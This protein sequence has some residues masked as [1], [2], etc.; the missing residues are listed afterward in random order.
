MYCMLAPKACASLARRRGNA[1]GVGIKPGIIA[2]P[3]QLSVTGWLLWTCFL[4]PG[5]ERM[6][7]AASF[8]APGPDTSD[9]D[10]PFDT[11]GVVD[12]WSYHHQTPPRSAGSHPAMG[13]ANRTMGAPARPCGRCP[14]RAGLLR[15][16]AGV[17][18]LVRRVHDQPAL[19]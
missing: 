14:A 11:E 13:H 4:P 1:R 12:G 2:A 16:E 18:V 19:V 8:F 5:C 6:A 17:S 10:A 7:T 9:R 3:S 15:P